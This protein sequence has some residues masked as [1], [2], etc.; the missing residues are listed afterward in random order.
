MTLNKC[1]ESIAVKSNQS[2]KTMNPAKTMKKHLKTLSFIAS[3][4]ALGAI[5]GKI[6]LEEHRKVIKNFA[7]KPV[8]NVKNYLTRSIED[9]DYKDY[10]FI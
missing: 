10:S 9:Y 3:G 7:S 4:I 2:N 5:A 8:L 1:N 6:A